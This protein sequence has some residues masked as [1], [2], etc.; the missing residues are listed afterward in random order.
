M[1]LLKLTTTLFVGL[2]IGLSLGCVMIPPPGGGSDGPPQTASG[3]DLERYV[4]R[5][6]EIASIPPL[7]TGGG[8]CTNTTADYDLRDDGTVGVFNRCELF[9]PGGPVI[10]ISGRAIAT[11]E[12]NASLEVVFDGL[13]GSGA[14]GTPNYLILAFA[15]DYSWALVGSP[16]RNSLFIL[17]RTPTLD[18]ATLDGI[19][20]RLP[21]FGYSANQLQWTLQA[22]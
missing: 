19:L 10:T 2:P 20:D 21:E 9:F 15:P 16:N 8:Q 1:R 5:Y 3:V 17:S 22:G 7:P 6:F 12:T 18:D 11:D 14:T 4:G 13:F